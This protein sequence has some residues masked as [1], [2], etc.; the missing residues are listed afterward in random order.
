MET[1]KHKI[2]KRADLRELIISDLL[3]LIPRYAILE[4]LRTDGYE[5]H[6]T[7]D[8]CDSQIYKHLNE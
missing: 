1:D 8:L 4:K 2:I 3:A 6:K 5:N 7:S